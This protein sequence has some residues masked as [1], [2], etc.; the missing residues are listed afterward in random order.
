VIKHL[1]RIGIGFVVLSSALIFVGVVIGV[2][3]LAPCVPIPSRIPV[4]IVGALVV[5]WFIGVLAGE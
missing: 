3:Y 5:C 1:K 2:A 4:A